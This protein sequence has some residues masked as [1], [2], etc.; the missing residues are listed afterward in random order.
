L[1]IRSFRIF[2]EL[3]GV[4]NYAHVALVTS[5][6]DLLRSFAEGV[7]RGR[8]LCSRFLGE[9]IERGATINRHS[10]THES[11]IKILRQFLLKPPFVLQF[12][13]E[14]ES[15]GIVGKTAAGMVAVD[16]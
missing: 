16:F 10:N 8:E 13:K 9:M 5:E 1:T 4:D 14:L 7:D 11:A 12:Q 2:E 15:H 3:C 6:W